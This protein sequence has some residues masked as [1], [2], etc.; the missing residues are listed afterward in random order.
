M[1]DWHDFFVVFVARA[2]VFFGLTMLQTFVLFFFRDVQ[3]V[4]NPSAGTA[5]Y[6]FSTSPAP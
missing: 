5:L 1:R 2:L 4:E 3:H 6:A